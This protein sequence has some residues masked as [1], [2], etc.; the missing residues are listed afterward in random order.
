MSGSRDVSGLDSVPYLGARSAGMAGGRK[1]G[2]GLTLS[3][4]GSSTTWV[5]TSPGQ[6][7]WEPARYLVR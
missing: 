3:T 4:M 6:L 7:A 2:R 1:G 5:S